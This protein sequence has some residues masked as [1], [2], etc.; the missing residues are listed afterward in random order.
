MSVTKVKIGNGETRWEVRVH[1]DGRGSKR[2]TK[3]FEKKNEADAFVQDFKV[4]IA[5]RI[6]DPSSAI[7]FKNKTFLTESDAWLSDGRL[8]FSASHFKRV[9]AILKMFLDQFGDLAIDRF[10]PEFLSKV[11]QAEKLKGLSNSSLIKKKPLLLDS[12]IASPH[13]TLLV[14]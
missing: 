8:R 6:K 12:K 3:R 10:N 9:S 2:I 14:S 5:N 7:S 11:Q 4:E 13:S 1:E